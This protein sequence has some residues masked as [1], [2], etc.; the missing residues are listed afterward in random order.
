MLPAVAAG[1][2]V[3]HF[4]EEN[5]TVVQVAD[6]RMKRV[7]VVEDFQGIRLRAGKLAVE[8]VMLFNVENVIEDNLAS[9]PMKETMEVS[10]AIMDLRVVLI[11][12]QVYVL[13]FKGVTVTEEVLVDFLTEVIRVGSQDIHLHDHLV[14]E[15]VFATHFREESVNAEVHVVILTN[16]GM[17]LEVLVHHVP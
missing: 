7:P 13:H 9:F 6:F 2:Y 15:V 11:A 1:E 12:Q 10:E 4:N 16:L 5:V 8:F 17:N 14:E 3:T